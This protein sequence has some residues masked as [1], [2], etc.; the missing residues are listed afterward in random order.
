LI[1]ASW[2]GQR[3]VV[4]RLLEEGEDINARSEQ[5]GTAL[6]VAVLRRDKD[7]I[8]ILVESGGNVYLCGKECNLLHAERSELVKFE[9]QREL[10]D[11][12]ELLAAAAAEVNEQDQPRFSDEEIADLWLAECCS[13]N[14]EKKNWPTFSLVNILFTHPTSSTNTIQPPY[15][16]GQHRK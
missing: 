3:T 13:S 1:I 15:P 8:R 6:N 5:Y 16:F 2:L 9:K 12:L 10:R 4:H 14:S 11:E 7:I